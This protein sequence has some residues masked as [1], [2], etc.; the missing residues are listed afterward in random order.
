MET[1]KTL[2][3]IRRLA[4]G[5]DPET[6]KPFDINHPYQHPD[7]IRAL[8]AAVQ[9]LEHGEAKEQKQSKAQ[10]QAGECDAEKLTF[11]SVVVPNAGKP[12][13]EEEDQRLCSSLGAEISISQLAELHGRT[14]GDVRAHLET[15]G[16]LE[17]LGQ[18]P[19]NFLENTDLRTPEPA[20]PDGMYIFKKM[21]V[22]G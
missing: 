6:G 8:F 17:K 3:I 13:T 16:Q 20:V 1:A 7:T 9:A 11:R 2:F 18:M 21:S 14:Y 22:S 10:E 15:L 5:V 4:D 19:A 12:W